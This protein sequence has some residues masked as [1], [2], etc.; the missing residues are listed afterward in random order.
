M[1]DSAKSATKA[2]NLRRLPSVTGKPCLTE[3]LL[4]APAAAV[5]TDLQ[6]QTPSAAQPEALSICMQAGVG[7]SAA[8]ATNLRRSRSPRDKLTT[9]RKR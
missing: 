3:G 8:K 9:Q 4:E 5:P 1:Q 6:P 7:N 2:K